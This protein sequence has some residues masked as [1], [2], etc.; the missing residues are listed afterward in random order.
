MIRDARLQ[1]ATAEQVAR[2]AV[3]K[4]IDPGRAEKVLEE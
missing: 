1:P 4:G 2:F 3:A